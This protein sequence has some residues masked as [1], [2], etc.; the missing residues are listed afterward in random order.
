MLTPAGARAGGRLRLQWDAMLA[1]LWSSHRDLAAAAG[2]A[3][4]RLIPEPDACV[5]AVWWD[6]G[7][8]ALSAYARRGDGRDWCR[9][10]AAPVAGVRIHLVNEAWGEDRGWAEASLRSAERVLH[11]HLG[12]GRP[13]WVEAVFH[14]SVIERWNFGTAA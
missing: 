10:Y 7:V 5:S 4:G 13:P 12:L 11:H 3:P 2:L 6:V 1:G 8:H 9:D 14:Q